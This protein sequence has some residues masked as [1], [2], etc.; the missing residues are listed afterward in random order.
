[1]ELSRQSNSDSQRGRNRHPA[2]RR[3][4]ICRTSSFP[5]AYDRSGGFRQSLTLR[6]PWIRRRL[7]RHSHQALGSLSSGDAYRGKSQESNVLAGSGSRAYIDER[8]YTKCSRGIAKS[9]FLRR[10]D[11]AR[12][13]KICRRPSRRCGACDTG[14]QTGIVDRFRAGGNCA[15]AG[16]LCLGEADFYSQSAIA[17]S[18]DWDQEYAGKQ[19][20]LNLAGAPV[21]SH[22]N[23]RIDFIEQTFDEY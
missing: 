19:L 4:A 23:I 20:L 21:C 5:A 9:F 6:R 11:I 8:R 3:I 12:G 17:N 13:R 18:V 10:S 14:R 16:G 7:P 22:R 2:L 15:R 1:M